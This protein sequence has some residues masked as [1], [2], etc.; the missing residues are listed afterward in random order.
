MVL[1]P[2]WHLVHA[3]A[4][5]AW[6]HEGDVGTWQYVHDTRLLA[7]SVR[8]SGAGWEAVQCAA[9]LMRGDA[10]VMWALWFASRMG[11]LVCPDQML[12]RRP[13]AAGMLGGLTEREWV[14]RAWH[15]P[16]A[17][18]SVKWSRFWWRRAMGA[19]AGQRNAW[20]WL[21]GRVVPAAT[22]TRDHRPLGAGRRDPAAAARRWQRHLARVLG[23]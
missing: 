13:G 19:L 17:S 16:A 22:K 21:L 18:P 14:V 10:A 1:P 23:S 20:P 15:S 8:I 3:S 6:S 11:S 5:W 9:E 12:A 7:E 4:H 2:A